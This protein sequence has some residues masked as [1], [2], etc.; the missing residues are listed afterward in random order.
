MD[1]RSTLLY[2]PP[3]VLETPSLNDVSKCSSSDA[4]WGE[5]AVERHDDSPDPVQRDRTES[6]SDASQHVAGGGAV[7]DI[8]FPDYFPVSTI[9]SPLLDDE[10]GSHTSLSPFS[11]GPT[12]LETV[13]GSRPT[14][15]PSTS[16]PPVSHAEP[17]MQDVGPAQMPDSEFMCPHCPRTFNDRAKARFVPSCPILLCLADS[18]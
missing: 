11:L 15:I 7:R 18:T 3:H 16:P 10:S 6:V 14:Q 9:S 17:S 5:A 12:N 8:S 1:P 13:D 2:N 4:T